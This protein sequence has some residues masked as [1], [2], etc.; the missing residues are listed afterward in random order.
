[1]QI[2]PYITIENMIDGATL[3]L[4]DINA[5]KQVAREAQLAKIVGSQKVGTPV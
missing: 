4:M 1:M 2:R 3:S 5:L